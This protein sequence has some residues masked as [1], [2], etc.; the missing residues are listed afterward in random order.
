MVIS[1]IH[2]RGNTVRKLRYRS[3]FLSDIHLGTKDAQA[4][5]LLDFLRRTESQYL[6]LVGDIVDLW[7]LRSGWYWPQIK[8]NIVQLV[9]HKASKG[10]AVIYVPGNHDELLRDYVGSFFNGISIQGEAVHTTAAGKRL[11][12][13]HG[14]EFDSVVLNSKWLAHLGSW[15]YDWLLWMN[16]HFNVL[17]RRLGFPYWSLSAYLKHRVKNAVNHISSFEEAL[18]REAARRQV[19]GLVCGHIH[20]ATIENI[21]GVLYINC[22]DWVESCTAV[23]E[24]FAGEL[25]IVRWM[26]ESVKLLDSPQEE[27][28]TTTAVLV[29][30]RRA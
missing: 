26:Q 24:D 5:Y 14:D 29:K 4:E 10:T 25:H 2:Q 15:A 7:K 11:L 16:R 13:L 27:A 20:K 28:I 18:A 23:V 30:P 17:R 8:N 19:D 9:M 6:Y 12:L 21:H 1:N 3:I 22:G